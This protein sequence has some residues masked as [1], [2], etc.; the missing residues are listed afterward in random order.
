[1]NTLPKDQADQADVVVDSVMDAIDQ[2]PVEIRAQLRK[3]IGAGDY[4]IRRYESGRVIVTVPSLG[5]ELDTIIMRRDRRYD[6]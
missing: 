3:A 6:A 4:T 5:I 1:M 2:Q